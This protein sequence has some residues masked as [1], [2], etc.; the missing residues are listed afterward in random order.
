V[1]ELESK[2]MMT[3]FGRVKVEAAKKNGQWDAAKKDELTEEH[4]QA[5]EDM[6]KPFETAYE[7]FMKMS[8]SARKAYAGSYIFGAKTEEGKQKRFTSIVERL[9]L[10]LNPMESMKK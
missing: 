3:D 9:N 10:N 1:T 8:K 2:G 5:F 4:L 7:N 6:L